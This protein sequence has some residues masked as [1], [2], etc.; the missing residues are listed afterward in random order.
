MIPDPLPSLPPVVL[1]RLSKSKFLSGL[2]CHKRLYLEVH[3]RDLAAEPDPARQA[4]LDSGSAVG[5]A[6][7]GRFP[8]GSLV[9]TSHLRPAEALRRTAEL[10]ADPA[11][12]AIYEGAVEFEHLLVRVDILVREGEAWRL[13]EVKSS[14]RV[15]DVHLDDLAVQC[16][17]L[18]GAGLGLSG[19]CLMHLNPEY[20]YDGVTLDL[21]QLFTIVDLTAEIQDRLA[22]V[23]A[24]VAAMKRML[25]EPSAPAI[26][27]DGHCRQPFDCPFWD[28]CTK[29]MP[30]RWIHRLPGG[31]RAIQPLLALG[32]RTMDEIP[33]DFPL[34]T[35]QRRVKEGEE[36]I[37][38]GLLGALQTVRY[39]VH[40][41]DFETFMP[42]IPRFAM[43]RPYQMIPTQWSN[44]VESSDGA[45]A[46]HEYLCADPR[47]PREELA[48]A[49][50][51]ALG[52]EGS[53][54]VYSSYEQTVL[55][56]LAEAFP[57]FRDRIERVLA[58]LWDLLPVIQAHY[59]HPDFR[60]SF[61]IKSVLPALVPEL[62]YGDLAIRDG[63]TAAG[64]YERMVFEETDWV[65]RERIREALRQYCRRDTLAMVALRQAL[66]AK[67]TERPA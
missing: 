9:E 55:E 46:H 53:I 28:H 31:Q 25:E 62:D 16:H 27:P 1:P 12:P 59:Y 32:I 18:R 33:A 15:K 57:S 21:T 30:P 11:V 43:T 7:R 26:E 60:G 24:R 17:V 58:R 44:H 13:I 65:E 38:P 19:V 8:G 47:D 50:L 42:G 64:Q 63:G 36:W 23:P 14:S 49:L 2:Q 41:L 39:P 10:I 52:E 6:A 22:A 51:A 54:C 3:H 45:L 4:L 56:S 48:A 37:G 61:S 20:L 67:A 34:T 5:M 35:I 29:A 40:H 66:L